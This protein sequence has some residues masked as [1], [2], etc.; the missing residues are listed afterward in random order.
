MGRKCLT[1]LD[2]KIAK[3]YHSPDSF[4]ELVGFIRNMIYVDTTMGLVR[5]EWTKPSGFSDV[6]P[7]E[8]DSFIAKSFLY[9]NK[10][11]ITPSM[12]M[13]L[14]NIQT[15][16]LF[17]PWI[18][19]VDS[20][21]EMTPLKTDEGGEEDDPYVYRGLPPYILA[22]L[23]QYA[24]L[25]VWFI[26]Y[27]VARS[28]PA[29]VRLP[30][31]GVEDMEEDVYSTER[32]TTLVKTMM[33]THFS[34][35]GTCMMDVLMS[36]DDISKQTHLT[37]QSEKRQIMDQYKD[38]TQ[39][40]RNLQRALIICGLSRYQLNEPVRGDE[41]GPFVEEE[42]GVVAEGED[43]EAEGEGEG[44]DLLGDGNMDNEENE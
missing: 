20:L 1:Q 3:L 44:V 28:I 5:P 40:D 34:Y 14:Q 2:A 29:N 6:S 24:W 27:T 4:H 22:R 39:K 17:A 11:Y 26:W 33:N 25:N 41:E 9:P 32:V 10:E 7:A 38:M 35:H 23:Y 19:L 8:V 12:R 13:H 31:D 30:M 43:V 21:M 37:K 15:L 42:G 36:E 16:Q 18:Q